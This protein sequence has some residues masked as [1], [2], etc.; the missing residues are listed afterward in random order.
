MDKIRWS[1]EWQQNNLQEVMQL[2]ILRQQFLQWVKKLFAEMSEDNEKVF[3]FV[4]IW[5]YKFAKVIWY[6]SLD[7]LFEII[8]SNKEYLRYALNNHQ[9]YAR[10]FDHIDCILQWLHTR[11]VYLDIPRK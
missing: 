1:V 4:F 5:A 10:Y 2:P 8:W 11:G 6:N 3:G 9:L 7:D